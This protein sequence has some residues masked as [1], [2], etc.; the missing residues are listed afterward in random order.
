LGFQCMP[1]CVLS[2][3]NQQPGYEA[4]LRSMA[5]FLALP[6]EEQY[7]YWG[8]LTMLQIELIIWAIFWRAGRTMSAVGTPATV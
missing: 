1:F 3:L 7:W 6:Y 8:G 2:L 4:R 5:G